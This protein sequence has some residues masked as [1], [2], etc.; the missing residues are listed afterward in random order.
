MNHQ[1]T[2]ALIAARRRQLGLTQKDLADQ[3]SISDRTVSKWERGAG[4]PD[5]SLIE[6]LADALNLT[7]LELLHGEESE[8]EKNAEQSARE[9][10]H[11]FR[12]EIECKIRRARSWIALLTV[13]LIVTASLV[14]WLLLKDIRGEELGD[15]E[16]SAA[17]TIEISPYI[18]ITVQDLHLLDALQKNADVTQSYSP[19]QDYAPVTL[20]EEAIAPYKELVDSMGLEL[21]Y[22]I[23]QVS[24]G[25]IHVEYGSELT[26]I[27]LELQE[28]GTVEKIVAKWPEPYPYLDGGKANPDSDMQPVYVVRNLD[29]EH[30]FKRVY[31]AGLDALF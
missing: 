24:R 14:F 12:P 27:I 8:P 10:L 22:F 7:V 30:F 29:N 15:I 5:I 9:T 6:P 2:G 3:L 26:R 25:H 31:E 23:V 18:I 17:E 13:M 1:K 21:S 19:F 20:D 28:A 4:F 11:T 16:I